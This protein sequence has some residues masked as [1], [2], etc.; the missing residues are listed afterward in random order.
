[1]LGQVLADHATAGT[2]GADSLANAVD[3]LLELRLIKA[4]PGDVK[5]RVGRL[6]GC[7]RYQFVERI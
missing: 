3:V 6:F 4:G 1:M 2:D 7:H 5:R